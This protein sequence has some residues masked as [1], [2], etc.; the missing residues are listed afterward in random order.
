MHTKSLQKLIELFSK[1]PTIGTRTAERLAYYIT[2]TKEEEVNQLIKAIQDVKSNITFCSCCNNITEQELCPICKD[3]NRD[4]SIICVVEHPQDIESIERM[5]SYHGIYHVLGGLLSPL[6]SIGPADIKL[7]E[8]AN[9][10]SKENIKEVIIA[11]NPNPNGESTA[12]YITKLLK[13]THVKIS[14]IGFGMAIGSDLAYVDKS[15]IERA[16]AGRTAI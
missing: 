16:F 6:D 13:Q 9:R 2:K 11:T 1:M 7:K 10:I 12:L 5:Q 15:T 14:R 8:L 4:H 3:T